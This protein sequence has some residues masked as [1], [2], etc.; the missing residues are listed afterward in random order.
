MHKSICG[1]IKKE[2]ET[3]I[4]KALRISGLLV[5]KEAVCDVTEYSL[6]FELIKGVLW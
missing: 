2:A 5:R 6:D 4:E 3:D 1:G